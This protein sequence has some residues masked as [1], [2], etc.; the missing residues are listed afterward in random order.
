MSDHHESIDDLLAH[1][2]ATGRDFDVY[3][4]GKRWTIPAGAKL[5][6]PLFRVLD[7]IDEAYIR[8][9]AITAVVTHDI[10]KLENLA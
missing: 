1:M 3:T 4:G 2:A 8:V 10:R 6:E 9:D 7:G 5:E